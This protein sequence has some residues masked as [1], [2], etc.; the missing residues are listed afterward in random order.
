MDA[1]RT[2]AL[3]LATSREVVVVPG[4]PAFL[5]AR[6][7]LALVLLLLQSAVSGN[8][9]KRAGMATKEQ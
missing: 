1:G 6:A 5:A 8:L 3:L 4:G 9:I 2:S 7:S